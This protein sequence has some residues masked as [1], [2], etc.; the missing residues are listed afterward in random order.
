M[1]E[2]CVDASLGIKWVVMG[3]P[4]RKKARKFLCDSIA[5]DIVL[6]APPLFEY[7]TESAL[8]GR[9]HTGAMT[10]RETDTALAQLSAIGVQI[11]THPDMIKRAREIA[12]QFDQPNI[13]D[14]L[15]AALAELRNCEFWTADKRFYETVKAKLTF[16]NYLTDYQ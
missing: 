6:I 12:R 7:E 2:R 9:L 4:W 10:I 16:V 11:L 5:V 3:E 13:Y 14:S 15:Y 8:Q 1:P